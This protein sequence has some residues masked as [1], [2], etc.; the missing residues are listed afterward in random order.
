MNRGWGRELMRPIHRDFLSEMEFG[1]SSMAMPMD[2]DEDDFDPMDMLDDG[3]PLTPSLGKLE[4]T[5]FFN[6]FCDDFD[7]SDI[8]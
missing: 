8:N 4:H 3:V 6:R 7:D 1:G 5:T 2:V